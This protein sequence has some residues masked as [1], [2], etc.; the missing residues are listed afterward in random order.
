MVEFNH[1]IETENI[2]RVNAYVEMLGI[3]VNVFT[4]NEDNYAEI[5]RKLMNDV[6]VLTV[7][8]RKEQGSTPDRESIFVRVNRLI[9]G[10]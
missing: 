10:G 6:D 3:G 4:L 1:Q 8:S 5:T 7:G 2:T 9:Q